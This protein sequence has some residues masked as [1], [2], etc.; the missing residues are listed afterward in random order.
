MVWI[1]LTIFAAL[2]QSIKDGISKKLTTK[3]KPLL[4]STILSGFLS[5]VFLILLILNWQP[6]NGIS[7][8]FWI[9]FIV[10]GIGFAIAQ[11]SMTRAVARSDLSITI[12]LLSF[13]PVFTLI[14]GIFLLGEFPNSMELGAVFLIIL[15]AY[16]LNLDFQKKDFL[17]PIKNLF[18]DSSAH[19]MILVSLIW[20]LDTVISKIATQET[21]PY[22]WAFSTRLLTFGILLPFSFF[23]YGVETLKVVQKYF[24]YFLLMSVFVGF[25]I[26][27]QTI[28]VINMNAT[29]NSA[30]LRSGALFSLLIGAVFFKE[31]NIP[32]RLIGVLCMILGVLLIIIF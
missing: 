31:K 12:P 2:G 29:L 8:T 16:I 15:G 28:A 17:I 14:F 6:I 18:Q 26:I 24:L 7:S 4:L 23:N 10:T 21:N 3:I 1:F 11:F 19:L 32:E 20:G 13:S 27:A 9:S 30:L 22:F 5:L 25:S